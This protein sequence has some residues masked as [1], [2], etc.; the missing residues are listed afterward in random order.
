MNELR[1]RFATKMSIRNGSLQLPANKMHMLSIC[2]NDRSGLAS[3]KW[4]AFSK[5]IWTD[6]EKVEEDQKTVHS[7]YQ[8]YFHMSSFCIDCANGYTVIYSVCNL[9]LK[10]LYA[11]RS[12]L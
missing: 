12:V 2:V 10:P 1:E 3:Y 7:I 4:T 9:Y 8:L 6:T 5:T 11:Q